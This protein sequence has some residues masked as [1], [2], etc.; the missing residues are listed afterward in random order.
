MIHFTTQKL[1]RHK[2]AAIE[3]S[4]SL[5]RALTRGSFWACSNEPIP[6]PSILSNWPT[7]C[8]G[9]VIGI[10]TV[11]SISPNSWPRSVFPQP[12]TK[13]KPFLCHANSPNDC[14]ISTYQKFCT[15][16]L[17]WDYQRV[18]YLTLASLI[19]ALK[20]VYDTLGLFSSNDHHKDAMRIFSRMK[21][22]RHCR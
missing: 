19:T 7:A 15:L 2:A 12:G 13:L 20:D 4:S 8:S 5:F 6:T 17:I 14:R 3:V 16:F 9:S 22:D 11:S 10:M 21:K 1:P 18:G